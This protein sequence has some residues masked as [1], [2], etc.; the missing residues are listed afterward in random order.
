MTERNPFGGIGKV[1]FG[2]QF[3][4]RKN[5][6]QTLRSR[7]LTENPANCA[8]VGIPRVGKSS[9]VYEALMGHRGQEEAGESVITVWLDVPG[10]GPAELPRRL[11]RVVDE[12]L[13]AR[14]RRQGAAAAAK[15]ERSDRWADLH[16]AVESFFAAISRNGHRVVVV[17]DEFDT[18]SRFAGHEGVF[19]LLKDLSTMPSLGLSLVTTSCW[20]LGEIVEKARVDAVG[21]VGAFRSLRLLPFSEPDMTEFYSI[22]ARYEINLDQPS[23]EAIARLCGAHP[24]LLASIGFQLVQGQLDRTPAGL[25]AALA[26]ASSSVTEYYESDLWRWL[27]ADNL[28]EQLLK[29]VCGA[30]RQDPDDPQGKRFSAYG[31]VKHDG[32]RWVPFS[33]HLHE[34]L[35]AL[36]AE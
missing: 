28:H 18:A 36:T 4:G 22:L 11:L 33:Q 35:K 25:E 6:L 23:R 8:V 31:L 24:F 30:S 34:H 9:L 16:A 5:E 15:A 19:A 3:I 2:D 13:D 7:L 20:P 12:K 26:A 29:L 10:A 21:F 17:L 32:Q 1:V 14:L 27:Q